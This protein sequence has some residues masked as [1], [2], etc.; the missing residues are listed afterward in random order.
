M[1][2][3][4]FGQ[5]ACSSCI[6]YNCDLGIYKSTNE[7][8]E[9]EVWCQCKIVA[10][11]INFAL[12]FYVMVNFKFFLKCFFFEMSRKILKLYCLVS[13]RVFEP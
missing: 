13:Y 4:H 5:R 2:T 6:V 8:F 10:Y 1:S 3:R 12:T 11:N 9:I 7:C